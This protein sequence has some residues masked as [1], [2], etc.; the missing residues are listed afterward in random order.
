MSSNQIKDQIKLFQSYLCSWWSFENW[1]Q[2]TLQGSLRSQLRSPITFLAT[3]CHAS[4]A[5]DTWLSSWSG[6]AL[7]HDHTLTTDH[8]LC[9][10]G[11]D[12]V[13]PFLVSSDIV[14]FSRGS[15]FIA[16]IWCSEKKLQNWTFMT[17][18]SWVLFLGRDLTVSL[19]WQQLCWCCWELPRS[20]LS[21]KYRLCLQKILLSG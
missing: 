12:L 9:T 18:L 17:S 3:S 20:F 10:A 21:S 1:D 16:T 15:T 13:T 2:K 11:A 6:G 7:Y 14:L 5:P 19:A 8:I 4:S